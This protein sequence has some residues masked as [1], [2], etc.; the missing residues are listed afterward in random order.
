MTGPLLPGEHQSPQ[1]GMPLRW[2]FH[3]V[4]QLAAALSFEAQHL[5]AD[6]PPDSAEADCLGCLLVELHSFDVWAASMAAPVIPTADAVLAAWVAPG[7]NRP[8]IIAQ[9]LAALESLP[10]GDE[11]AEPL[12]HFMRLI[13]GK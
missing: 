8:A 1:A 2:R 4:H 12:A 3:R 6:M 7:A 10:R 13:D 11:R 9:V 5:L